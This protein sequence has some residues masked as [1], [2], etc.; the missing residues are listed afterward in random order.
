MRLAPFIPPYVDPTGKT[1][2]FTPYNDARTALINL[3]NSA[4]SSILMAI[5][6][7]T[8][9]LVIAA[10]QAKIGKVRV[11]IVADSS[12][13]QSN[14][15]MMRAMRAFKAAGAT[16]WI[17]TSTNNTIM[18]CKWIIVDAG[19]IESGS[20]N[21]SLGAPTQDNTAVFESNPVLATQ[22]ISY[23]NEIA[24]YMQTQPQP[25]LKPGLID[26]LK[27]AIASRKAVM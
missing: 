22:L 13:C 21:Y 17:G 24:T 27:E 10:I 23:W 5:F 4:Q 14:P 19:Q 26:K 3:I 8:D 2:F 20:Y 9:P 6:A 18:H 25:K 16:I 15:V 11:S 1:F 12:Q 7:L